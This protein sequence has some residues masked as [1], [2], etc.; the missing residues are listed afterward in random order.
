MKKY[1]NV[2]SFGS[3]RIGSNGPYKI[4]ARKRQKYHTY[5]CCYFWKIQ[6]INSVKV[7]YKQLTAKENVAIAE[8]FTIVTMYLKSLPL[9]F[10]GDMDQTLSRYRIVGAVTYKS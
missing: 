8:I 4:T 9:F 7:K 6:V 2:E 5:N 1:A 3:I 10:S